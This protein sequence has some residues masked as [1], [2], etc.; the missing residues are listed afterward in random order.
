L[1][2]I[3]EE[4]NNNNNNNSNSNDDD[5]TTPLHNKHHVRINSDEVSALTT[6]SALSTGS[7]WYSRGSSTNNGQLS[8]QALERIAIFEQQQQESF[9]RA[10]EKIGQNLSVALEQRAFTV[11][12]ESNGMEWKECLV[13]GGMPYWIRFCLYTYR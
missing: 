10:K 9:D 11:R 8:K 4:N 13:F 7:D 6:G 1:E 3:G 5:E 12:E 2:S